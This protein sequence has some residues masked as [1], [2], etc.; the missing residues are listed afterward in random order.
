[1]LLIMA[2]TVS[3]VSEVGCRGEI[4]LEQLQVYMYLLYFV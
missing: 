4:R 2:D 1:M 3:S